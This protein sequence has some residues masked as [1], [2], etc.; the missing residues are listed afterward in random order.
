M[1]QAPDIPT[2]AEQGFPKFETDS[3]YGMLA[4]AS[5]S[6]EAVTRMNSEVNRG[7]SDPTLRKTFVERG[8]EPL[9]GTPERLG[10]HI[11]REIAKYAEIV[12]IANMKID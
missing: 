1:P 9:G 2:I 6:K 10:E 7:L 3:W 4:A 5:T 11:R 12:K 8:L